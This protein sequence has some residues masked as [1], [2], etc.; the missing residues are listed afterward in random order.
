[1]PRHPPCALHSLSHKHS[2]KTTK[3]HNPTTPTIKEAAGPLQKQ[4]TTTNQRLSPDARVHYPHVKHPTH[5][6]PP[7]PTTGRTRERRHRTTQPTPPLT[8]QDTGLIPQ[9]PTACHPVSPHMRGTGPASPNQPA[10]ST[11]TPGQARERVVLDAGHQGGQVLYVDD[12]TSEHP[13]AVGT[14]VPR[15]SGVCSLERR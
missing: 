11:P 10:R 9:G 6:P 5:Q 1:M 7:S 13:S 8:E 12:S 2:T 3:T 15:A 4:K 14:N